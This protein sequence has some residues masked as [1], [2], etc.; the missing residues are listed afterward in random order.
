MP[1]L[2]KKQKDS[3]NIKT[4]KN[5]CLQDR[6]HMSLSSEML[7]YVETI[8]C[9]HYIL[10]RVCSNSSGAVAFEKAHLTVFPTSLL[11]LSSKLTLS[12]VIFQSIINSLSFIEFR[13]VSLIFQ[14]QF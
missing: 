11:Y 2:R 5:S 8:P 12:Y 1:C 7:N 14:N 10:Q 4:W 3:N 6:Q 9:Q 13:F